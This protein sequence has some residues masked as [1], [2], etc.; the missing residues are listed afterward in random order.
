MTTTVVMVVAAAVL[1]VVVVVVVVREVRGQ[2][3]YE[4][5]LC[6]GGMS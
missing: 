4:A 3:W 6:S 2:C 5:V 1:V